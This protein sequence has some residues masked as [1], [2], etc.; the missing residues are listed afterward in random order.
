MLP[1]KHRLSW[2]NLVIARSVSDETIQFACKLDWFAEPVIGPREA[3][4]RWL[5]MNVV[6][7][8]RMSLTYP[9]IPGSH[10]AIAG[11]R[12]KRATSTRSAARNGSVA[13]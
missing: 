4:T 1:V 6:Q 3:R 2:L 7:D 9:M 13:A 8:R 10:S 12:I 5:A 11:N